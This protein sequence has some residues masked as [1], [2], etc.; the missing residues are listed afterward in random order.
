M[1]VILAPAFTV[2]LAGWKAKFWMLIDVADA[3]PPPVVA[4]VLELV[5]LVLAALVVLVVVLLDVLLPPPQALSPAASP[6][7]AA[8]VA[9]VKC[10][11]VRSFPSA[12]SLRPL[13][14]VLDHGGPA[15]PVSSVSTVSLEQ[16]SRSRTT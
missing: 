14:S 12:R 2:V 11:T 16:R 9:F 10:R 6:M 7:T 3:P 4:V 1:T 13:T 8:L 15:P 5:V